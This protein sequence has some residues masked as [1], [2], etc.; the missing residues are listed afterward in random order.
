MNEVTKCESET[1]EIE[2]TNIEATFFSKAQGTKLTGYRRLIYDLYD[3][4]RITHIGINN[5]SYCKADTKIKGY[6][7]I[8]FF[9]R[10]IQLEKVQLIRDLK[11][12]AINYQ[13]RRLPCKNDQGYCF[14]PQRHMYHF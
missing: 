10:K 11:D 3:K 13:G 2:T 8:M 5:P 6:Q 12:D 9:D 1:E 14:A 4:K 7:E